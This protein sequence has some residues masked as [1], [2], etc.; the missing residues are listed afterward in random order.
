MHKVL[1]CTMSYNRQ[2][3]TK[4]MLET[5]FK[6]TDEPV[7]MIIVEQGSGEPAKNF[8]RQVDGKTTANGSTIKVIWNEDNVGIP[9]ALNQAL[10]LRRPDQHFMKIDNDVILPDDC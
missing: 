5:F 2:P 4:R 1:V 10:A 7:D 9:K 3:F 6:G 8:C